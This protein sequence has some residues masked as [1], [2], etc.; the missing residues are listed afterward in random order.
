MNYT[1]QA[2]SVL[3][4]AKKTAKDLNH[5]YVGT[6]H[7]LLGLRKVYSGVAG[8]I[9]ATNGVDEEK[10]L[11]IVDE[12]VSQTGDVSVKY[13]PEFSP[14]LEYILEESKTEAIHSRSDKIGTEHMLLALMHDADCVATRI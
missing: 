2:N 13:Q 10:I 7:L 6:E 8:Q 5:P 11:K 3:Q 9:L 14:R 1:E 12:L 4:I